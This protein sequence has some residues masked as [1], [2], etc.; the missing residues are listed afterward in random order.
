MKIFKI[1]S[2][3]VVLVFL[4]TS[5]LYNF[6]VPEEPLDPTDPDT[7]DIS[8]SSEIVPIFEA[9]CTACHST[10]NQMPDLTSGNAFNSINSSRYVNTTD[11]ASSLIYTKASPDGDHIKYTEAEAALVLTWITQGAQNN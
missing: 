7:P 6:I 5:C 9:K 11:P 1:L 4:S 10:G 3:L 8:F 2:G